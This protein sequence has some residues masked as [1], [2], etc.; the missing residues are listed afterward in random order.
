MLWLDEAW[1]VRQGLEGGAYGVLLLSEHLFVL[2][3]NFLFGLNEA[4]FRFWPL[5]GLLL[6]VAATARLG[7][8]LFRTPLWLWTCLTYALAG[9]F[10]MHTREFKPYGVDLGLTMATIATVVTAA[11]GRGGGSVGVFSRPA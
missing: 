6:A 10:V 11:S 1:R 7:G 4:A 2:I 8:V 3:S 5:A 9:N